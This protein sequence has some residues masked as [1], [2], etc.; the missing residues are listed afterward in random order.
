MNML[1]K[2]CLVA[3]GIVVLASFCA[4]TDASAGT[5][6][7][8]WQRSQSGFFCT[9]VFKNGTLTVSCNQPKIDADDHIHQFQELGLLSRTVTNSEI[10]EYPAIPV[11]NVSKMVLLEDLR[12][13]PTGRTIK[14]V[15]IVQVPNRYGNIAQRTLYSFDFPAGL[16]KKI[17]WNGFGFTKLIRV[18]QNFRFG[19]WFLNNFP[20]N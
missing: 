8:E 17:N 5:T 18:T 6:F 4:F 15:G 11:I 12:L 19:S 2:T 13:L 20:H 7:P 3:V 14:V 9:S 16:G 10:R 1:F